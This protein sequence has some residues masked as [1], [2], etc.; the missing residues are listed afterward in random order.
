MK[1]NYNA[2]VDSGVEEGHQQAVERA[3]KSFVDNFLETDGQGCTE[4]FMDG[5]ITG[6][7]EVT[8]RFAESFEKEHPI[9]KE[10]IYNIF[11]DM[12]EV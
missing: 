8:C 11:M 10:K 6:V 7:I 5:F 1:I 4:D 3:I 12:D 2:K 9:D